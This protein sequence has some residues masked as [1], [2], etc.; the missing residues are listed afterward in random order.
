MVKIVGF[1]TFERKDGSE[2]CALIVQGGIEAVKSKETG[3]TYFTARKVNVSCT[4]EEEM[5]ESLLGSDFPG[6]IQ[7]VEVEAYEYAIPETGEMVT[8]THSYEYVSEEDNVVKSNVVEKE[9]VL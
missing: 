3:K 2:F 6:S 5:C 9:L 1:K 8:L 4:F 7:K